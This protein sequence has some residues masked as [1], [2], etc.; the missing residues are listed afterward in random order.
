[1]SNQLPIPTGNKLKFGEIKKKN[2]KKKKKSLSGCPQASQSNTK[3]C[4]QKAPHQGGFKIG[5]I[6]GNF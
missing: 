6:Q 4:F 2:L 5:V 3:H 1:M